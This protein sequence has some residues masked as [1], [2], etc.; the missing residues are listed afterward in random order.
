MTITKQPVTLSVE[1]VE[2]LCGIVSA[3]ASGSWNHARKTTSQAIRAH[4]EQEGKTARDLEA[5]LVR[6]LYVPAT[7]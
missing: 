1:E 4:C 5:M 3:Y 7:T 2:L 6:R